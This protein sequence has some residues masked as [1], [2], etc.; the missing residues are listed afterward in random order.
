MY[1]KRE[2]RGALFAARL[3]SLRCSGNWTLASL[4]KVVG[5]SGTMIHHWERGKTYPKAAH[6]EKLAAAFGTSVA[7]LTGIEGVMHSDGERQHDLARSTLIEAVQAARQR[8]AEAAALP[9]RCIRITFDLS[10]LA[11]SC[12]EH[13]DDRRSE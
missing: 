4:A 5:V 9:L 2:A 8:I 10:E 13:D 12:Q 6:L 11:D 7:Y 1:T 3:N